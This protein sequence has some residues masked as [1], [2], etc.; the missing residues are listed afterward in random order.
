MKKKTHKRGPGGRFLPVRARTNDPLLAALVNKP[1]KR[2]AKVRAAVA[3]VRRSG[4]MK[5]IGGQFSMAGPVLIGL[6][7]PRLITKA[8]LGEKDTGAVGP[9]VQ[10]GI[11]VLLGLGADRV[12]RPD[13]AEVAGAAGLASAVLRFAQSRY[14][15]IGQALAGPEDRAARREAMRRILA[16]TRPALPELS[17]YTTMSPGGY[18]ATMPVREIVM[19]GGGDLDAEDTLNGYYQGEPISTHHGNF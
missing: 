17:G 15:S 4:P 8:V 18:P 11:S 7:V 19:H 5:S 13:W 10:A 2:T 9:A 3:R 12:L 1:K 16:E 6:S 14:P